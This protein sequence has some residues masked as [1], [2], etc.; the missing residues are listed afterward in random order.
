M[1]AKANNNVWYG[2]GDEH[3][4]VREDGQKRVVVRV[5]RQD[6]RQQNPRQH[7]SGKHCAKL[8][9]VILPRLSVCGLTRCISGDPSEVEVTLEQKMVVFF[10]LDGWFNGPLTDGNEVA[11]ENVIYRRRSW[12]QT[13]DSH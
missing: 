5:P 3:G 10:F 1:K 12:Q 11:G 9:N 4:R 6:L 7:C 8:A 13:C 2:L